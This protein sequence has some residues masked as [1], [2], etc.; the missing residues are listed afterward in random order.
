MHIAKEFSP[1][2][3]NQKVLAGYFQNPNMQHILHPGFHDL[4]I[5]GD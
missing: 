4:G 1:V 5:F 2:V 3:P